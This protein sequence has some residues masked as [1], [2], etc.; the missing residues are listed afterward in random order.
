[1]GTQPSARPHSWP[2]CALCSGRRPR[3]A[4][5]SPWR[6][7]TRAERPFSPKGNFAQVLGFQKLSPAPDQAAPAGRQPHPSPV[8]GAG[9]RPGGGSS[10][11][12]GGG[13]V[14]ARLGLWPH[15]APAVCAP[16]MHAAGYVRAGAP[17]VAH[18]RQGLGAS[19]SPRLSPRLCLVTTH[20]FL[21]CRSS[22][23][24]QEVGLD[25]PHLNR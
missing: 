23:L 25:R 15:S 13:R 11:G 12:G 20:G 9:G 10:H 6:R 8:P 16:E 1:M 5:P 7:E 17:G 4:R 19:P 2:S 24:C 18:G 3:A 21:S 14:A 22:Q